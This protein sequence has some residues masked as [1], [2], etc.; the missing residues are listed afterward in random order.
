MYNH[1]ESFKDKLKTYS[2]TLILRAMEYSYRE[3]VPETV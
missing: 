1:H 3:R 2:L